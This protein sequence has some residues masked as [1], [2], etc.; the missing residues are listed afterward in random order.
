MNQIRIK[1][2]VTLNIVWNAAKAN[3]KRTGSR[4]PLEGLIPTN[5]QAISTN[6]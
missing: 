1:V 4:L 5:E 3:D 2:L 6:Q